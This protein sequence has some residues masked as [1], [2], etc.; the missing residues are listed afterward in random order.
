MNEQETGE[1]GAPEPGVPSANEAPESSTPTADGAA[2][3]GAAPTS[4]VSAAE[5]ADVTVELYSVEA[6]AGTVK[7]IVVPPDGRLASITIA[8][9]V[10]DGALLRVPGLGAPDPATGVP[11]ELTV[12]VRV[13]APGTE[14]F[15]PVPAPKRSRRVPILIGAAVLAILLVLIGVPVL[16]LSS[17][18]HHATHAAG[19]TASASPSASPSPTPATPEKYQAVLDSF[20]DVVPGL[21]DLTSAHTVAGVNLAAS[22]Y[23]RLLQDAELKL[24]L[25]TPP[26]A[27]SSAHEQFISALD[28][29]WPVIESTWSGTICGGSSALSYIGSS[30]EAAQV[31]TTAKALAAADPAHPYTIV[32][33]VPP[34]TPDA[35]RQLVL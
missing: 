22:G 6:A 30:P 21:A 17:S 32:D 5:A 2:V 29:L 26:A 35:N 33:F 24:K 34:A 27:V 1:G 23:L 9:G 11:G 13:G 7:T 4:E 25:I 3:S 12:R 14:A 28:S 8:P 31:R 10:A 18:P 19:T 20:K 16:V 15:A